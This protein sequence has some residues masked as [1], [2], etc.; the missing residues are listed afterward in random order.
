MIKVIN[1]GYATLELTEHYSFVNLKENCNLSH[2]QSKEMNRD[3][4]NHF[5]K[6]KY[7][8][9][10]DRKEETQIDLKSYKLAN[11][12][13]VIG[14]AIVSKAEK[15][16]DQLIKEQRLFKN[17]FAFFK[18]VKEAKDWAESFVERYG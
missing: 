11:P 4:I 15:I 1:Y 13:Q 14:I 10:V 3:T 8:I 16:F 2:E 5:G 17:S 18:T 6:G 9:I 7:V 12:K